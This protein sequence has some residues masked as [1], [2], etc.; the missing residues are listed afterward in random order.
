MKLFLAMMLVVSTITAA[1]LYFAQANVTANVRRDL[2]VEFQNELAALHEVQEV[3]HASL[4]E[5]CRSLALRPRIHAALE[6]DALDLLYLSAQDELHDLTMGLPDDPAHSP[7]ALFYRFLDSQG[8]V[9]PPGDIRTVG[10]LTPG[11]EAQLSLPTVPKSQ[12]TGYLQRAT[13]AGGSGISEVIVTPIVSMESGQVIAALVVGFKPVALVSTQLGAAMKSGIWMND[14]LFSAD[15]A[16]Q[17]PA[18]NLEIAQAL[19]TQP[20]SFPLLPVDGRP[21][22]FFEKALNPGSLFP[23]ASEVCFFSL[24][25]SL[26]RERHLSWQILGGGLVL[27]LAALGLTHVISGQFSMPVEQLAEDSEEDRAHRQRAEQA[28]EITARELQRS[29]RFASDASHQL[30]TPVAVLRAG[31]EELLA[32]N[33]LAAEAREELSALVHQTYR[34]TSVVEDLLLLAKMDDGQLRINFVP[35]NLLQLVE[36][37]LDD[38][39]AVPDAPEVEVDR[40]GLDRS[41]AGEERYVSIILQNLLENARKY[42]RPGGR[43]RL[44]CSR[45]GD[46]VLLRIGNTG[47][48]IRPEAREHIFE[49]FHRGSAGEN[50]PGHGLGLNLA[51]E[52]ARMHEGDLRLLRSESDWTE[53]EVRFQS[54]RR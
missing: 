48:G 42:N 29:S 24:A 53:F 41:I 2:Q 14:R 5:R 47:P 21:H 45:D 13:A 16:L 3:R 7:P 12:Q 25:D 43:I 39:S 46:L 38:L 52:L 22:L 4:A 10:A 30:K 28:L 49:R 51:R 26:A 44:G 33:D 23:K 20:G 31:L 40:A 37:M 34:F 27:L 36:G 9:I 32:R 18:L 17:D 11:E 6:D 54:A 35:V 1:A 19:A 50:V 15:A 8:A